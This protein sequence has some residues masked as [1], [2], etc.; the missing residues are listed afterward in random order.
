MAAL[1][2]TFWT[3]VVEARFI[4]GKH[5][6]NRVK[7]T[8]SSTQAG[9]YPSSGGIPLPTTLGMVRNVDYVNVIQD[10][11]P[12]SAA[13]GA[14]DSHFWQYVVSDH[15]IHGYGMAPTAYTGDATGFTELPTA[16]NPSDL[17]VAPVMYVEAVG[18]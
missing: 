5:K 15:A 6:R 8:L 4:E 12:V 13:T 14:A 16:W 1:T 7:L 3:E 17:G 10:L 18:W 9:T 11:H 2:A